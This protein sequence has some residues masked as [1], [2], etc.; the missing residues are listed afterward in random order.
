VFGVNP[1]SAQSHT[2]FQ[3][4]LRRPFPLLIDKGQK[5]G[6]PYHANGLIVNAEFDSESAVC[7]RPTRFWPR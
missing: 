5:V 2:S 1:H 7:R 4:K 3:K 6:E